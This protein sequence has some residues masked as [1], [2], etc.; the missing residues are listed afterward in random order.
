MNEA[1]S[2]LAENFSITCGGP[3]HWLL[4]RMGLSGDKRRQVIRRTLFA[5]LVTW[6]PL[7][8]LSLIQGQAYGTHSKIPFLKDL[9]VNVR[10][11][12]AFPILILAELGIDPKWRILVLQFLRSGL[13]TEKELPSFEAVIERTTRLRDRFLPEALL[14]IA[15]FIPSIFIVKTELLMSGVSNW[16]TTGVGSNQASLAGWW[17]NL[18]SAPFFRFILLRWLWRMCLWT[19]FLWRASRINLYLVATHTDLAAG[20]GFLS[21]GQTAFSPIVFAGGA[22]MAAQVGNAIAYQGASLSSMKFPMIAYGVLAI[23]I[24]IVPLLVVTPV[25]IRIKKKALLEYGVLVTIH[26][27]LFDRKWIQKEQPPDV[28]LLG[29][30]DPSSLIDL[31]SSFAVI[32]QMGI[33]PIDR[34]TLVTLTVA[35][36]LPMVPVVLYATPVDVLVRTVL[37][38]LG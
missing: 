22:V 23:I 9:A 20:L 19:S 16:H 34:L 35:A 15:A 14:I 2:S 37:K 11:L 26:N 18:V 13:V 8:V 21:Q 1:Q 33:V 12:I 27:H 38:M 6:L 5:A 3:L 25:L 30:Q 36:A 32:R 10:F 29:N 4:V 7:L 17:F 31:G 28:V 24:L